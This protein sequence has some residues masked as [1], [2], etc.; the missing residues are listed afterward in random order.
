MN[1]PNLN[2]K[3]AE[4]INQL[5]YTSQDENLK[6][7]IQNDYQALKKVLELYDEWK[8]SSVWGDEDFLRD[9]QGCF[10]S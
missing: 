10:Q 4:F 3:Q 7:V 8:A 5:L 1:D 9:P 2:N 6:N